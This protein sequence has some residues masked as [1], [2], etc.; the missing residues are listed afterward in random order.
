[1]RL[2]KY[3]APTR[4]E[5]PKEAE[6]PSHQMML[7]AGLIRQHAA[8]VY[9]ILPMGWRVLRNIM[10]IIR[11]EIDA[12]G[13]HEFFLPALSPGELWTRSGRWNTFGDNMFRLKDRKGRPMCLAPTHEE[14]FA[15]IAANDIQSYRDLPQMWYQIQTKFR[16]EVR[17][18]SGLLRVRQFIMKD[19]YSFDTTPEGLDESYRLQREAYL[20]IF[21]RVGLDVSVVK[22]SSGAMGGRDCEEFMVLSDSGDDEIVNCPS[23][24]YS[25]NQEIAESCVEKMTGT[26]ARLQKVR[27]PGM[28]TIDEVSGFLGVEP[29]RLVKSLVY[30]TRDGYTFV[31]V[32]GDHQV[33]E[34]KL[35]AALGECRP[36]EPEEVLEFTGAEIGFVSPIGLQE[37]TV[38]ADPV[39]EGTTDL[40]AGANE[41]NYHVRG[42]DMTRDIHVDRY[43]SLR[44]VQPGEPCVECGEP[45]EV[46]RAIEVGH[47]FKLGTR[48]SEALGAYFL[49]ENGTAHPIIM[50]SYGIGVERIMASVI[51]VKFNGSAMVWPRE[52]APFLVE[53][54]PLNVKSNHGNVI[55]EN[56][57]KTLSDRGISVLLDDRDDRAGVKFKDADLFGAPVVVV[58]GDRNLNEGL[59]ELR[60]RDE[61]TVEKINEKTIAL[62]VLEI[63]G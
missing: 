37:V 47:I 39:L 29:S 51:E 14:V 8:G 3:F 20:N 4:K 41:D 13:C 61:G 33:D 38:I 6:I 7:R 58:I 57:Y 23:C 30:V 42:V 22:A 52:I 21:R 40:V 18:R 25:A 53:I 60:V 50:G 9:S 54:L 27:T 15:E 63:V 26:V 19:A 44:A 28:R 36:A 35:E 10:N 5:I 24:G 12:I 46:T 2:S 62:S 45:L 56:L 31:L 17:P 16:D 34:G 32:R 55:A 1:M 59:V 11:E 49:D 48:Y 43:V